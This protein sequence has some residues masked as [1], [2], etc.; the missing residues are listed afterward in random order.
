MLQS[1]L[2]VLLLCW[3]AVKGATRRPDN[4]ALY[5]PTFPN[6]YNNINV[7]EGRRYA[8]YSPYFKTNFG[9]S[10][11][12]VIWFY[13][14]LLEVFEIDHV[15]VTS[16]ENSY[17][18]DANRDFS[19]WCAKTFTDKN[20][21]WKNPM[22]LCASEGS[23]P[24][25]QRE[26]KTYTCKNLCPGR[27]LV[28]TKLRN[29]KPLVFNEVEAYEKGTIKNRAMYR[30]TQQGTNYGDYAYSSRG[31]DGLHGCE[32]ST[33]SCVH[34]NSNVM[35]TFD[36][37][38]IDLGRTYR[39]FKMAIS[40]RLET[41]CIDRVNTNPFE[42]RV[43]EETYAQALNDNGYKL[44]YRRAKTQFIWEAEFEFACVKK[45]V[46]RIAMFYI[47]G[48][49][50]LAWS[51]NFCEVEVLAEIEEENIAYMKPTMKI[52]EIGT[53]SQA[54]RAAVDGVMNTVFALGS[55]IATPGTSKTEWWSVDLM[56][57]YIVRK[58]L[59][60]SRVESA[61][62]VCIN[63]LGVA[64]DIKSIPDSAITSSD[65]YS[66]YYYKYYA[67]SVRLSSFTKRG[68]DS[69]CSKY[70]S[71][72]SW[73]QIDLGKLATVT[74]F[75]FQGA[76]YYY[77]TSSF[78]IAYS[79][80]ASGALTG[81]KDAAGSMIIL[82]GVD[83]YYSRV[84][85]TW[86]AKEIVARRIRFYPYTWKTKSC[87]RVEIHGCYDAENEL[88][89]F[90][91]KVAKS[92][93]PT[94]YAKNTF[95]TCHTQ[96]E[97]MVKGHHR[98]IH[99]KPA[100][101]GRYVVIE[102]DPALNAPLKFCELEVYGQEYDGNLASQMVVKQSSTNGTNVA[103]RAVDGNRDSVMGRGSCS[104]TKT[105]TT[106]NWWSVD[107]G[108]REEIG[109]VIIT[110]GTGSCEKTMRNISILTTE[111]F[112][113]TNFEKN[114]FKTCHHF[115]GI[116]QEGEI[117]TFQCAKGTRGRYLALST[118]GAYPLSLCEVEVYPDNAVRTN[119]AQDKPAAQN[120]D[121]AG[122]SGSARLAVD[123][124]R[125]TDPARNSMSL[126]PSGSLT[127]WSVD[128]L[129]TYHVRRMVVVN[130]D[131]E[132]AEWLAD[133]QA[134]VSTAFSPHSINA[135]PY[136]ICIN[137]DEKMGPGEIRSQVCPKK[138]EGRY[139]FVRKNNGFPLSL[140][141][142]EVY[143]TQPRKNL[144]HGKSA[145]MN[146]DILTSFS[147]SAPRATDGVYNNDFKFGSCSSTAGTQE[148]E[149]WAANLI[150]DYVVESV[151]ITNRG[152]CC[153]F[154]LRKFYVSLMDQFNAFDFDSNYFRLCNDQRKT[155]G[156]LDI[157][158]LRCPPAASGRHVLVIKEGAKNEPLVLCEVE[159]Y[160]KPVSKQTSLEQQKIDGT[161]FGPTLQSLAYYSA[162]STSGMAAD[163]KREIKPDS[164]CSKTEGNGKTEWWNID[165]NAVYKLS[166]VD[167]Y[168]AANASATKMQNMTVVVSNDFYPED[169]NSIADQAH[170]TTAAPTSSTST[171]ASTTTAATTT[172]AT[173][174]A[175]TTT[176][177]TGSTVSTT[178]GT[179]TTQS[180]TTQ[181]QPV[182]FTVCN[183][184]YGT[185]IPGQVIPFECPKGLVGRYVTILKTP[186]INDPL[187][188]CEV[189]MFG[190]INRHV[191]SPT[192]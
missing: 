95:S 149:W 104:E 69:W 190:V 10:I 8:I 18:K 50:A 70:P 7:N 35:K 106:Q 107:L 85:M 47:K 5:K 110:S 58:I 177:T 32:W 134:L 143:A 181:R 9:V 183:T 29:V 148:R 162:V 90:K 154:R 13:I 172:A 129:D 109:T 6:S 131:D 68:Q 87:F 76:Y 192:P 100:A 34:S 92:F 48:E 80:S 53:T 186:A 169:L 125:Y 167:V 12:Q 105:S 173:T 37:F 142:V 103:S 184:F 74:G 152:D 73:L 43:A 27:Y 65:F 101:R 56:N 67:K 23:V 71:R 147:S 170:M 114:V 60:F 39:I 25:V 174:A 144:A 135:V 1:L 155:A 26:V 146:T 40:N 102:K 124:F 30:L 52:D 150:D 45:T 157:Q 161:Y 141:E 119:I 16:T 75:T 121:A 139:V 153:A 19:I 188:L 108:Q 113:S 22:T 51:Y 180:T 112:D 62:G 54:S 93:D 182:A 165:L 24:L 59:I 78:T 115:K 160:G 49:Y 98:F 97:P 132:R 31:V 82:P 44:C 66:Y 86:L 133:F 96:K 156:G 171:D 168:T 94:N 55:C 122:Y 189:E 61:E 151:F 84:R 33:N 185:I 77:Y 4:I 21:I 178:A 42:I 140:C 179:T 137:G 163:G 158:E 159:V 175:T 3:P 20:D 72:K 166:R 15:I 118:P 127:W 83:Y 79:T 99:C 46:G 11:P 117:K 176:A 123:G 14:D 28:F 91:V 138:A 17:G 2:L 38:A 187:T 126:T 191:N 63:N 111:K 64:N 81:Y 41:C 130:R 36:Y 88:Q 57:T 128:L 116:F 120:S 164:A 89:N 145:F 136:E